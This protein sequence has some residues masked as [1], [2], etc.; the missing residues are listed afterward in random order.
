M[1]PLSFEKAA[2]PLCNDEETF[3]R[4][5][6]ARHALDHLNRQA[7]PDNDKISKNFSKAAYW[8]EFE[9]ARSLRDLKRRNRGAYFKYQAI[10]NSNVPDRE[11]FD[12]T[13][14]LL[15]TN[16]T[17]ERFFLAY[18]VAAENYTRRHINE[19]PAIYRALE[20]IRANLRL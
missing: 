3:L 8:Y 4:A 20:S 19:T 9:K 1:L 17:A 2:M 6:A 15:K 18:L 5:E 16:P 7:A 12:A 13:I 11:K 10:Q 14:A